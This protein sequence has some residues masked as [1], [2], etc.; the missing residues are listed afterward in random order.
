MKEICLHIDKILKSCE[1]TKNRK[2][3]KS[4]SILKPAACIPRLQ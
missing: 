4:K 3:I 1:T 2:D